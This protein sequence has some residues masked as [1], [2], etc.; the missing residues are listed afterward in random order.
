MVSRLS[1]CDA[2]LFVPVLDALSVALRENFLISDLRDVGGIPILL[3][4][5]RADARPPRESSPAAVDFSEGREKALE[6]HAR[7]ME[8]VCA[9][10]RCV[11]AVSVDDE[12]SYQVKQCNGVY[13]LG[14]CLVQPWDPADPEFF[15]HSS[16]PTPHCRTPIVSRQENHSTTSRW[17]V[18]RKANTHRCP[19]AEPQ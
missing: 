1:Y 10:S 13:L 3:N 12:A 2:G 4:V 15:D 6:R 16:T 19:T 7:Q 18:P 11:Q 17:A 8:L 14:R 5:L 9:L